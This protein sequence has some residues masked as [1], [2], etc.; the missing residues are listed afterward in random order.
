MDLVV[1]LIDN[2][3]LRQP[4]SG[5]MRRNQW[6]LRK[7]KYSLVKGNAVLFTMGA[8]RVTISTPAGPSDH[9]ILGTKVCLFRAGPWRPYWVDDAHAEI[10]L[11]RVCGI[12][13]H[14]VALIAHENKGELVVKEVDCGDHPDCY[15]SDLT[16]LFKFYKEQDRI[17]K[18][19]QRALRICRSCPVKQKCDALDRERGE[20]SDWHIDYPFP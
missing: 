16:S 9:M 4:L 10:K 17:L 19:D 7:P 18:H 13:A 20:T 1:E 15:M 12:A 3:T 2:L 6:D 11:L 14:D 8:E 5:C